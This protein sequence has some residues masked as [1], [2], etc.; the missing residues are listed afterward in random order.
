MTQGA[1]DRV[2][3]GAIV[4]PALVLAIGVRLALG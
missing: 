2:K 1:S 4:M 3:V